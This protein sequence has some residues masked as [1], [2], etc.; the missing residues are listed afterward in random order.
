MGGQLKTAH[1]K[2][3]SAEMG[4]NEQAKAVRKSVFG[5]KVD[6]A[7]NLAGFLSGADSI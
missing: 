5:R 1:S 3:D 6:E 4:E 7:I 2:F